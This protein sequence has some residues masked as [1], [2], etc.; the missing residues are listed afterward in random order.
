MPGARGRPS[1]L[2]HGQL[3]MLLHELGHALHALVARTEFQHFAGVRTAPDFVEAPSTLLEN[4]AWEPAVLRRWARHHATRE[5]LPHAVAAQLQQ[6][7]H[8]FIGI[9][10]Q[11]QVG[12]APPLPLDPPHRCRSPCDA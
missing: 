1:L 5:P 10:T 3:E 7:R 4:F 9:E 12:P 2:R 6:S 11:R 8:A